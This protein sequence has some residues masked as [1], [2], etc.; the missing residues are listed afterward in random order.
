M[1]I[2]AKRPPIVPAD[3]RFFDQLQQ[4]LRA[5]IDAVPAVAEAGNDLAVGRDVSIEAGLDLV[6][7]RVAVSDRCCDGL[8]Q[9]HAALAGAAVDVVERV[10]GRRHRAVQRQARR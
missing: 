2:R 8:E 4:A 5:R 9:L 1:P 6:R 3:A 7:R 10:D